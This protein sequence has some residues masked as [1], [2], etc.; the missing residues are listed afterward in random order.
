MFVQ[1]KKT[2][3]PDNIFQLSTTHFRQSSHVKPLSELNVISYNVVV[4]DTLRNT[5]SLLQ[6]LYGITIANFN[7]YNLRGTLKQALKAI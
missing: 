3:V 1:R 2:T 6:P 5:T 4:D 7:V